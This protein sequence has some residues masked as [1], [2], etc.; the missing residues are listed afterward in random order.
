MNPE[1]Y[2]SLFSLY[3]SSSL[4]Y[5]SLFQRELDITA[6]D[7]AAKQDESDNSRKKLVEQSRQFKKETPEVLKSFQSLLACGC[8]FM[9][10]LDNAVLLISQEPILDTG[11]FDQ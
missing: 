6:N 4:N 9:A 1:K 10:G 11:V 8:V 5:F 2:Q 7:L 3:S